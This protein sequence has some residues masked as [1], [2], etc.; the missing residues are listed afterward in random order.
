M[1]DARIRLALAAALLAAAFGAGWQVHAWRTDAQRLAAE[2]ADQAAQ[3]QARAAVG[4]EAERFE[5]ARQAIGAE[6]RTITREVDRVIQTPAYRSGSPDCLDAD[7]LR[8][9]AAAIAGS[10]NPGGPADPVPRPDAAP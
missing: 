9:L 6:A 7:G 2:R 8:Q 4:H 5:A 1:T 3:A 10:A